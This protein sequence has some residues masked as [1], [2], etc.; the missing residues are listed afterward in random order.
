MATMRLDHPWLALAG[1]V[2]AVCTSVFSSCVWCFGSAHRAPWNLKRSRTHAHDT[3]PYHP[4]QRCEP[5]RPQLACLML[6][7][8]HVSLLATSDAAVGAFKSPGCAGTGG[9]CVLFT[10]PRAGSAPHTKVAGEAAYVRVVVRAPGSMVEAM[11][12]VQ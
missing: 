7:R 11:Y 4:L 6:I 10:S 3:S 5:T 2:W 8:S 12:G 9:A 1:P